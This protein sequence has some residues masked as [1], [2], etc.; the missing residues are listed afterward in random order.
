MK[1][2]TLFSALAALTIAMQGGP[3]IAQDGPPPVGEPKSFELPTTETYKLRNGMKV[4]LVPFGAVPKVTLRAVTRVGNLNDGDTPWISDLTA[5]MLKEG[6]DGKSAVEI[7]TIAASMGGNVGVGVGLDQ[8]SV[9]MDV[10]SESADE[11]V[12][13]IAGIIQRPDFPE[14]AFDRIKTN[15]VRDLSVSASQPQSIATAAFSEIMYPDH[16]YS[17]AVLPDA[18]EISGLTLDQ[19]KAFHADNFGA[20][21]T[22]LYVVGKFD[23]R[24]L[25]KAIKKNFRKWQKGSGTLELVPGD[26]SGPAVELIDRPGAVQ[27]TIRL[28]KRIPALDG[29]VAVSAANTMLGGYFSSRITK[30]IREDKGY[31]YSPRSSVSAEVGAAYWNEA[32]DITSDSTGP[33]LVEIIKE[34]DDL[35]QNPPPA[36]ELQGVQNYMSGIYV[37][38]LASRGGVASQLS[39]V[40]LHGLGLEYLENY[41]GNVQ[42]LTPQTVHEAAK[43]HLDVADMSLVVV[44]DMASV[45]EQLEAVPAFAAQ[46]PDQEEAPASEE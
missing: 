24:S 11:A 17:K 41:V 8:T 38:R 34:I 32:A 5:D 46:L 16:P 18:E 10:L 29:T 1:T 36:E 45:R 23:K 33:A 4:T 28:G 40:N 44:G 12:A 13:L 14:E 3:S 42:A 27:S 30:N 25:K 19:L 31:T 22:H 15:R 2:K 35:V 21:R 39:F 6:A 7:A 43:E 20:A 37:I 9:A 26:S